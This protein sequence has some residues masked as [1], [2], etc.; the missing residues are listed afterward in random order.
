MS[1]LDSDDIRILI[2]QNIGL[3]Y[4]V[5]QAIEILQKKYFTKQVLNNLI[6]QKN[7]D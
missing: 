2:N 3:K 5:P 7:A 1:E 4:L 6:M